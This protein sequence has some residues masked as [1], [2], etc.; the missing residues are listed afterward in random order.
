LLRFSASLLCAF[1][2]VTCGGEQADSAPTTPTEDQA[3]LDKGEV[4]VRSLTP[5]GDEGVAAEARAVVGAP[6]DK[7]FAVVDDCANFKA[8]M[9]RV[10]NSALRR[11]EGD[12]KIC[13]TEIGMPFPI[14]NLNSEVRSVSSKLPNGGFQRTWTLVKGTYKRNNGTWKVEPWGADGAKSL[15]TYTLDV[16][17]DVMIPDAIIRK[18]QTGSLPDVFEALRKRVG[19][20]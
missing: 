20:P 7:V 9:P 4:L 1:A 13:Y 12:A 15:V 5:T 17:P 10:K 2:A 11:T 8:F 6:P 3:Q 16:N 18:A 19:S 14:S